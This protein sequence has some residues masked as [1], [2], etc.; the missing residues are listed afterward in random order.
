MTKIVATYAVRSEP[1][2][3]VDDLRANLH[4][5]DGFAEIDNRSQVGGWAHEGELRARQRQACRDMGADWAL[6]V[7][8][9]ER[10]EDSA[11]GL[12]PAAV[13]RF[14]QVA[15]N[16]IISFPLRE[17]W[18][19][20]QMRIDGVWA[21]KL[22][23]KRLFRLGAEGERQFHHKPIHCGAHPRGAVRERVVLDDVRMYH[24]KNIEPQNRAAR[25][26]AYVAADR[27]SQLPERADTDWSWLHDE[28]GLELAEIEPGRGFSPAYTRPYH[29]TPPE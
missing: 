9:D 2:W 23:R 18:T 29:F 8:P 17:M 7:D 1:Q 10:L 11:V 24:L 22:P 26:N 3:L 13:E 20:T 12:V 25:A 5:V 19:P 28:T 16:T 6:F 4:W 21:R 14:Q 15:P 27:A